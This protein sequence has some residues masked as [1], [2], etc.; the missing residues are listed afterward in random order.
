M[1]ENFPVTYAEML[2]CAKRELA[3][4][5]SVYPR[6]VKQGR[7]KQ[8]KADREILVMAGIIEHFER[9]TGE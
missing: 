8:E 5:N 7:M 3:L 1:T 9:L 4:R 6:F 2:A